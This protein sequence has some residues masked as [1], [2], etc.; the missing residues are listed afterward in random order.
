[1]LDSLEDVVLGNEA[2]DIDIVR[3]LSLVALFLSGMM[4]FFTYTRKVN[5]WIFSWDSELTF[6]PGVVST[7][8][9]VFMIAPLYLR[10]IL[11]RNVSIYGVISLLLI[12]LVFSSFVELAMGGNTRS[13][14]IMGLLG[15]A[16]ILSWLG[17]KEV[18]GLAWILVLAGG[19]YS[20]IMSN[21]ALG[22]YGFVYI[23]FGFIG[24][25]LHSGLNPGELVQGIKSEY[26]LSTHKAIN[27]IHFDINTIKSSQ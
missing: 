20:V 4:S 12:L 25:V 15:S 10:G 23:A 22:F 24:L 26:S 14:L 18:A 7:L 11:I 13:P 2:L 27:E 21:I 17:I 3:L 19:V 5:L 9:A 16:L 8:L 1:M 6:K